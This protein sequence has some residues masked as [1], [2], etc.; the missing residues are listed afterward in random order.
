MYA[1]I[2]VYVD[3]HALTHVHVNTGFHF[4]GD[5][6]VHLTEAKFS[7]AVGLNNKKKNRQI[8][9]LTVQMHGCLSGK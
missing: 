1:Y 6:E 8:D 4:E 2:R 9:K 7:K 5:Q 3:T